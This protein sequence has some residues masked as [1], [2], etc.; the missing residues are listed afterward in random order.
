MIRWRKPSGVCWWRRWAYRGKRRYGKWCGRKASTRR[1]QTFPPAAAGYG[2]DSTGCCIIHLTSFHFF[3]LQAIF[4]DI[5]GVWYQ[6]H[7]LWWLKTRIIMQHAHFKD[8]SPIHSMHAGRRFLLCADY[9]AYQKLNGSWTAFVLFC[10]VLWGPLILLS[11]YF[12]IKNHHNL[13]IISYFLS[14]IDPPYRNTWFKLPWRIGDSE[15]NAHCYDWLT[16]EEPILPIRKICKLPRAPETPG[17]P[18]ALKDV[19]ILVSFWVWPAVMK[20]WMIIYFNAVR[21][22]ALPCKNQSNQVTW[23]LYSFLTRVESVP[24]RRRE[25]L[26]FLK[27][28][29]RAWF[30]TEWNT[31]KC[32]SS[33]LS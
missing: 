4:L 29:P 28:F 22:H 16:V 3:C 14:C 5:V 25:S 23:M 30:E 18:L 1:T 31:D 13:E 19:S 15:V 26:L 27:P 10:T 24:I 11:R 7:V 21:C 12:Y 32:V 2:W 17:G 8:N 33:I 20:T 9:S 6:F